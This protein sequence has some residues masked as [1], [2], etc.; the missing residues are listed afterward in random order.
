MSSQSYPCARCGAPLRWITEYNQWYCDNCRVYAGQQQNAID[1]FFEDLGRGL[2]ES[3]RC[4]FC[5]WNIRWV[6]EHNRW[7]CDRCQRYL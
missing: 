3:P 6:A 7:W 1:N 4:T 2:D 5:G